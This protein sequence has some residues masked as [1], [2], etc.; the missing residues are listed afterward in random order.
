MCEL[1]QEEEQ[2]V[3]NDRVE[4]PFLSALVVKRDEWFK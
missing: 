3:L 2:T 1:T 4:Y